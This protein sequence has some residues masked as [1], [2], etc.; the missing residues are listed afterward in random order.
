MKRRD[1]LK[2][3]SLL[4]AALPF[5]AESY[6]NN[7]EVPL[8]KPPRLRA[9]DGVGLIS[10]GGIIE[11]EEELQDVTETLSGLGLHVRLGKHVFDQ[12]G[13]LAGRDEERVADIQ[14]MFA[15]PE[16]KMILCT[17]GG[18]WCQ[19]ATAPFR[20]WPH[21]QEPQDFHGLQ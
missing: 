9:G 8:L 17:R 7:A 1:F 2:K 5:W 11:N 3:S 14:A 4:A 12:W 20:L 16:I 18:K 21:S 6:V 15:D 19:S 13:Y 10:P